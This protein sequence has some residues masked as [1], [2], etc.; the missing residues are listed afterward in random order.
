MVEV[1]LSNVGN[2]VFKITQLKWKMS[3]APAVLY[4]V[5]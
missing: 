3:F 2:K 1:K 4:T 5:A